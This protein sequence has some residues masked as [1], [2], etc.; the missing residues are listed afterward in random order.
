MVAL[1]GV[2]NLAAVLLTFAGALRGRYRRRAEVP[3]ARTEISTFPARTATL[4]MRGR[5]F[6]RFRS[7]TTI[8]RGIPCAV[9]ISQ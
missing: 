2:L 6:A 4:P 5:R 3:T 8:R 9:C 7:S 1:E